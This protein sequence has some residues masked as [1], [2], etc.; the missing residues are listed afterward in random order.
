MKIKTYTAKYVIFDPTNEDS[1]YIYRVFWFDS[2]D[3][4]LKH[5]DFALAKE[6]LDYAHKRVNKELPIPFIF[7]DVGQRDYFQITTPVEYV[8]KGE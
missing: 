1:V 2:T 8:Y 5:K 7:K 3:F 6:A 4:I